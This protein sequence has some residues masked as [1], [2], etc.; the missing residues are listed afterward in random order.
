MNCCVNPLAIE[1]LE[2]VTAINCSVGAGGERV[3][4]P[5]PEA[6]VSA[7]LVAV[8]VTFCELLIVEGAV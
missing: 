2:G 7:T 4:V 8:T 6:P 1:G 3:T 5:V